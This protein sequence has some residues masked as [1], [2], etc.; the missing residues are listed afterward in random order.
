MR[1]TNFRLVLRAL[2]CLPLAVSAAAQTTTVI[3][4]PGQPVQI[5]Q[6]GG[7]VSTTSAAGT[8]SALG[9]AEAAEE[10]EVVMEQAGQPSPEAKPA[11]EPK[12]TRTK[13]AEKLRGL[14]F[15]RR[16]SAILAAWS[17]P[18]PVLKTE[19]AG[20]E[21]APKDDK[22]AKKR[23]EARA[24]KAEENLVAWEMESLQYR[25]TIGDWAA[26]G[27]YIAELKKDDAD[28]AQVAYDRI[29][30]SLVQGPRR[31]DDVSPQGQQFIEKNQFAPV[32][33]VRMAGMTPGELKKE[34]L[35]SLG[36]LLR[37]AID[38]GH[39]PE[40]FAPAW[41]Q[42][43]DAPGF[44]FGKRTLAKLFV[45]AGEAGLMD[46]LLPAVDEAVAADDREALNLVAR[47]CL[48]N[49]AKDKEN[50]GRW[51]EQA[52]QATLAV[53]AGGKVDEAEKGEALQRAVDLAPKMA[54]ELGEQWLADSFVSQPERGREI[55]ASIGGAA[56]KALQSATNDAEKRAKLL[57]LQRT[58]G[59]ALLAHAPQRAKE[60][61]KEM[62]VLA[63]NWLREAQA[64]LTYDKSKTYGPQVQRDTYGNIY[65]W[66]P[67][68]MNQ[69]WGVAGVRAS[70]VLEARP[71][72]AWLELVDATLRP[73]IEATTAQLYLKVGE[74]LD[75]FPYIEAM[76]EAQPAQARELADEFLRVWARNNNPNADRGRNQMFVYSYGFDERAN[77]IP[78]TRSKQERNLKKLGELV[79]RLRNAGIKPSG[80]LLAEAFKAAHGSAEVYRIETIE[81]IF[82]EAGKL[83]AE[84]FAALL[85]TMRTNLATVWRDAA[86]QEKAK[87]KRTK[88]DVQAE[89]AAGY[90]SARLTLQRALD[91][92][93]DAWRLWAVQAA[94]VHDE[95]DWNATLKKSPKFAEERAKAFALFSK[96]AG[97]YADA[98]PPNDPSKESSAVYDTWFYAA[99]GASDLRAIDHEKQPVVPEIA[100]IKAAIEALGPVRAKR[101]VELF[102]SSLAS[103]V[104]TVNPAVKLRYVREGLAITGES[105]LVRDLQQLAAYYGDL[106]TEIQ[107]RTSV[108]GPARVGHGGAFGLR[109]DL[110]HTKDIERESGGFGKYLQNQNN[111][112]YAFNYGRPTENYRDKFEEG[113]RA[114]L[115]E[116]FEVQSIVFNDAKAQSAPD[117]ELG[118]RVT[119]YA[120]ILLKPRG[121]Q[122]DRVPSLKLDLDFLDISGYVVLPVESSVL[123]I[124][125]TPERG[126]ARPFAAGTLTQILDEKEWKDGKL[127]LEIKATGSGMPGAWEDLVEFAHPGLELKK[128]EDSGVQVTRFLEDGAGVECERRVVYTLE[129]AGGTAATA[130]FAFAKPKVQAKES[131]LF[132]YDDADLVPAEPVVEL[133]RGAAERGLGWL[134]W[135]AILLPVAGAAGFAWT[136]R[137][138]AVE[139][140]PERFPVPSQPTAFSVLALLKDIERHGG[141]GEA[142][143]GELRREIAKL[144]HE[145]FAG[146]AAPA[147]DLGA[148]ARRWAARAA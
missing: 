125:A 134:A 146:D 115:Q 56:A 133:R 37:L 113:A 127:A 144:E 30:A 139:A 106:V 17:K 89:V 141:L 107:L 112:M 68:Q 98:L 100:K 75:A 4:V 53:L 120:Y 48:A 84:T 79:G 111:Q 46:G 40:T 60:W 148:V 81:S 45:A 6:S 97:L 92:Q 77:G 2:A 5:I 74:D 3:S 85:D 108:D 70:R 21:E 143:R 39:R 35:A 50:A 43:A 38:Q 126:D 54:G 29:L 130:S 138:R 117:E 71:S 122:V 9:Y 36:Q 137:S 114:A 96:A 13:R 63:A 91:A 12:K 87:T 65:Y 59:E 7:V 66:D 104:G 32:D 20:A 44:P 140:A 136:R 124:D 102:A 42:R 135:L 118:W 25:V 142:E 11:E 132:R 88:K 27:A 76:A 129:S 101:H 109:V 24:K 16:S 93:P 22:E 121:A 33:I 64:S 103:R 58:A 1:R 69:Q 95:N 10:A 99:L 18:A 82:G 28:D 57:E 116:H 34:H 147:S 90:E 78:L 86:A 110:R 15:D 14:S 119:P 26:V 19:E 123:P 41:K 72:P 80:P 94:L 83:D 52:W 51:Q 49:M 128:T 55:L 67:E 131:Q 61:R 31:P 23:E 47:M 73:R 105:K 62:S 8:I 145:H